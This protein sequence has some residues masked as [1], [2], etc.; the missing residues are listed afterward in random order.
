MLRQ[1]EDTDM[2][3]CEMDGKP[4]LAA[5]FAKQWRHQVR[6]RSNWSEHDEILNLVTFPFQNTTIDPHS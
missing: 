3:E 2:I 6:S 4:Y 1:V 5:R